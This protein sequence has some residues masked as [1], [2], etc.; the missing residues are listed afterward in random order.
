MACETLQLIKPKDSKSLIESIVV[1]KRSYKSSSTLQVRN[2][3]IEIKLYF[4]SS[5]LFRVKT[6]YFK[7]ILKKNTMLFEMELGSWL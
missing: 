5:E 1:F 6:K 2:C 3:H 4:T 7:H